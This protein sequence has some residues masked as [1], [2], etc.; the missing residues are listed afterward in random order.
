MLVP[1]KA[2]RRL[3]ATVALALLPLACTNHSPDSQGVKSSAPEPAPANEDQTEGAEKEASTSRPVGASDRERVK[4]LE[5]EVGNPN[6]ERRH[7][8]SEKPTPKVWFEPAHKMSSTKGTT[9]RLVV[10]N[11]GFP[12]DSSL[13]QSL[14][15]LIRLRQSGSNQDLK[16]TTKLYIPPKPVIAKNVPEK[17]GDSGHGPGVAV[18]RDISQRAHI[19]VVPTQALG[20]GWY[21]L[22]LSSVPKSIIAPFDAEEPPSIGDYSVRF[23]PAS[24]PTPSRIVMCPK[25]KAWKGVLEFTEPLNTPT[26]DVAASLGVEVDGSKCA[27]NVPSSQVKISKTMWFKCD[28]V[29]SQSIVKFTVSTALTTGS[30]VK[31]GNLSGSDTWTQS[32]G[33]AV[34]K[35]SKAGPGCK[36]WDL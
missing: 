26:T 29:A 10:D 8:G 34:L 31:L 32:K 27:W 4:E 23:N 2:A 30:G 3:I 19:E 20:A 9:L 6:S 12:V 28:A 16:F 21:A 22:G 25:G 14:V 17:G 35:T 11:W 15:P 18:P 24:A 7:S 33:F 13:L 1:S 5:R 36:S